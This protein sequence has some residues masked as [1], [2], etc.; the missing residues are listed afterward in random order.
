M[1]VFSPRRFQM[2]HLPVERDSNLP[3]RTFTALERTAKG[4]L[5]GCRMCGNC[6]LQETAFIC[7]M[8]CAKG[9]RNGFCGEATAERCVVDASRPCTWRLIFER[10]ERMGRMDKLLEVNAPINGAQAGHSAWLPFIKFWRER[11]QPVLTDLLANRDKFW[12]EWDALC[13]GFRQP[14]WWQS[15]ADYH[16]PAYNT[17]ISRLEL[18]L[19][20]KP[21][22]VTAEIEPPGDSATDDLQKKCQ[23][24]NKYVISVNF[25]DN[26]FAT[27]RMSSLACCVHC[28]EAGG[29]AVLQMQARDRSR[30]GILSD[31]IGASALGV[32]N[33][34]CLGGDYH[35]KTPQVFPC[36]P[37]QFDIDAVQMLWMLR[38]LRDEGRMADGREIE[39]RPRYF[40]GAAG[41]PFTLK[42]EYS[43]LRMEK[44]VNA[45]AQFIQTQM[46]FD[47]EA[48]NT[49]MAAC[50]K[51]GLLD[52][53][54]FLAGVYPLRS[55][56]E[57]HALAAEPGVTIPEEIIQ[58]MEAAFVRDSHGCAGACE[59]QEVEG[60]LIAVELMHQLREMPGVRGVHLM[61]GGQESVVPVL[62]E[63]AGW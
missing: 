45:G 46:V 48:F 20:Q 3:V 55:A 16:P 36:Q 39:N 18:E 22:I 60:R 8:T 43:A 31:V 37:E 1:P 35:N 14:D 30:N 25:S 11:G 42:A 47:L 33:I 61:V 28:L 62:L 2:A 54:A 26:A 17:A 23:L 57:A 24:L 63:E 59:H 29:E 4:V 56:E 49:W 12:R 10:S 13:Y 7:P 34:L 15:D 9:L 52:K 32:R 41:A 51:R 6:I 19:Q 38:R 21:F 5:F 40:L 50:D 27:S 58:R 44:K 53:A